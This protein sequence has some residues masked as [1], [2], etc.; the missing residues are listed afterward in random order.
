MIER[1]EARVSYVRTKREGEL[2]VPVTRWWTEGQVRGVSE[3]DDVG[4]M[5]GV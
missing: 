3:V 2:K 1:V 4:R 5:K